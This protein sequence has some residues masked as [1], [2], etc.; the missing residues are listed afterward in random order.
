MPDRLSLAGLCL[1]ALC[2]GSPLRG[3][4]PPVAVRLAPSH[5]ERAA[6]DPVRFRHLTIADGLSQNSVQAIGRR[7]YFSEVVFGPA[8]PVYDVRTVSLDSLDTPG[9]VVAT[10]AAAPAP[11]PD[12]RW[13][14]Y[15]SDVSG[16]WQVMVRS[17]DLSRNDEWQGATVLHMIDDLGAAVGR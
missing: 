2:L 1:A 13:L 14:A 16:S 8:E 10:H 4:V 7:L 3:Q 11:S 6:P 9:R 15:R 5:P 17:T 12:E